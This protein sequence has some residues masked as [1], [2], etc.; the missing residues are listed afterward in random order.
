MRCCNTSSE[1]SI[2]T[3]CP[4]RCCGATLSRSEVGAEG[5]EYSVHQELLSQHSEY[6]KTALN[7]NWKEA[8]K[9]VI[10]LEDVEPNTC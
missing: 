5:T 9:R 7:D 10:T 3:S 8:E 1:V 4:D 2:L 6:F